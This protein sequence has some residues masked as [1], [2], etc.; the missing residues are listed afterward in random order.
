MKRNLLIRPLLILGNLALL[1]ALAFFS[2]PSPASGDP[3]DTQLVLFVVLFIL[4]GVD[5]YYLL[6]KLNQAMQKLRDNSKVFDSAQETLHLQTSALEAAANGIVITDNKGV[7]R[8]VNQAFSELSGFEKDEVIGKTYDLFNA[9]DPHE[10]S[11]TSLCDTVLAG[12]VWHGN[13]VKRCKDGGQYIA[14]ETITP[15]CDESGK[16]THFIAIKQDI[17]ERQQV[18]HALQRSNRA[19]RV[20][21]ACNRLMVAAKTEEELLSEI[22]RILITTGGYRLVW[23]GFA[24]EDERKSIRAVAEAGFEE[25]YLDSVN[26]SWANNELGRGPTGTAIRTGRPSI[27]RHIFTDPQFAPWREAARQRGYASSIA[28]PF[29]YEGKILG[30][31]NIYAELPDAFDTEEV[32]LLKELADD[33]AFGLLVL[34]S[35]E[36]RHQIQHQ[37]QQSE[38]PSPQTTAAPLSQA[39]VCQQHPEH[40]HLL[41]VDDEE[42]VAGFMGELLENEGY[43]VTVETSSQAALERFRSSAEDFDLVILDKNMPNLTGDELAW[44]L[45]ALKPELPIILCTGHGDDLD[46]ARAEEIGIRIYLHKPVA[47]K[48]LL[49]EVETQLTRCAD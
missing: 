44:Q 19:L 5:L 13:Q 16:I 8:W 27:C 35:K 6:F 33:L 2:F 28:I 45:L 31:L 23:I 30:A 41:I 37:L 40:A 39:E 42:T 34:R 4:L 47:A 20:L 29:G 14:E 17:T 32:E 38:K 3:Q 18:L 1:I 9:D 10:G 48:V 11:D 7:I 22:C 15:V 24:E 49:H 21:S 36:E 25:G 43:Q 12:K 26:I 46:K